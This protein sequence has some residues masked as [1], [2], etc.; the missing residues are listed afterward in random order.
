MLSRYK[1]KS[2]ETVTR[3][4]EY[5]KFEGKSVSERTKEIAPAKGAVNC[6]SA[7]VETENSTVLDAAAELSL[8][9]MLLTVTLG[10]L[11]GRLLYRAACKN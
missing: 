1:I 3:F 8:P 6:S 9:K 2:T 7:D 4:N 10:A 5:G 11:I